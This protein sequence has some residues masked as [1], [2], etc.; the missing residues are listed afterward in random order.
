MKDGL[1][2]YGTLEWTHRDEDG[3]VLGHD[4]IYNQVQTD[5]LENIVDGL[6]TGTALSIAS[7]AIGTGTGQAVG[8]TA[9]S[10]ES[11]YDDTAN[12]QPSAVSLQCSTTFTATA[13]AITEAGLFTDGVLPMMTYNDGL[14]VT[15]TA[16][17]SLQIDWTISVAAA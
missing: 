9:L 8:D 1:M 6:D 7:M 5:L 17:D 4:I 16:T 15:L 2:V 14:S 11:S 13:A 3:N 10:S 12:T